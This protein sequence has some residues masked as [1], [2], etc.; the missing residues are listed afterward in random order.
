MKL[1]VNTTVSRHNQHQIWD[2]ARVIRDYAIE[3]WSVFFLVPTGR[4]E[5]KP[6]PHRRRIRRRF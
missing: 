2:I 3:R 5:K 4:A 1:Q 6:G